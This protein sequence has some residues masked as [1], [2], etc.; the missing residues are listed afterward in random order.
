MSKRSKHNKKVD[1]N[2]E[3]FKDDNEKEPPHPKKKKKASDHQRQTER[4][5]LHKLWKPTSEKLT[6]TIA[7]WNVAGI[8]A[9]LR[10]H[11][12]A[13]PKLVKKYDLDVL[14]LQET[15]LQEMHIDDPKLE[16]GGV[17]L[18]KEGFD[19]HYSCSITKK[20][21][22]GVCVFVKRQAA[23]TVKDSNNKSNNNGSK[24]KQTSLSSFF[25][26]TSNDQKEVNAVDD[27][28]RK[29][30]LIPTNVSYGIGKAKHDGEGRAITLD[31]PLFSMTNLYVPNSGQKLERLSYRTEE[32]DRDLLNYMKEKEKQRQRPVIW[33]GDLNVAPTG[34]ETWNE[35]AKHLVKN[36]GTTPEERKS[37]FQ[38]LNS[39]P[40]IDAFTKLHPEAKGHYTYW[41]QRAGNRQPNKGL[42]LDFFICSSQLF[43]EGNDAVIR[44]C[45]MLPDQMG[46]DH[47]PV[48]LEIEIQK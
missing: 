4:S 33:L 44:D 38:Q 40:Y 25:S 20:G 28:H 41:S 7:S 13:L 1:S 34:R 3:D 27:D 15:K 16:I 8:R 23:K 36:A 17:L 14:C 43:E 32:W 2:D 42:R 31:F 10:N 30:N 18:N 5:P 24:K 22:S 19:A 47:C 21:Y 46:S 37:Y 29:I 26:K 9:L 45:Y 11:P 12:E 35:G 39:G 6:F 48:V